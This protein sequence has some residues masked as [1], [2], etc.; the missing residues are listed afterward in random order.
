M[1]PFYSVREKS[2]ISEQWVALESE[3]FRKKTIFLK[4]STVIRLETS[5]WRVFEAARL[6]QGKT[7][8]FPTYGGAGEQKLSRFF[9]LGKMLFWIFLD[10]FLDLFHS[11][12][13]EIRTNL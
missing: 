3:N 5:Y 7:G 12:S 13:D 10:Y 6:S 2:E 1:K 4:N 8:N 11:F 9:F